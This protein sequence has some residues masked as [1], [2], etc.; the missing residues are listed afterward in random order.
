MKQLYSIL[1]ILTIGIPFSGYGRESIDPEITPALFQY[2]DE[3]TVTYNV[4]DT[5]LADF[6]NAW[7]WVWI[8]GENID[9]KYNVN[10]ANSDPTTSD[11]AKFTKTEDNGQTFFSITFVPADF[12]EQDIS[13]ETQLGM[14]LKGN[15]WNNGN[16]QTSDFVTDFWDGSFQVKLTSPTQQPLFVESGEEITISAETPVEADFELFINDISVNSQNAI[17]QFSYNHIVTETSGF[18]T[19]RIEAT[20]DGNT[21]ETGFQYIISGESI[22]EPRPSGII[23]GI[24]YDPTDDTKVT[25]CL[26][27]PGKNS[28]YALGDFSDWDVLPENIMKKDGGYFWLE[29]DGLTAGQEYTFQ[30]LVDE[31]LFIADPFAE[32]IL[33]PDDQYIPSS[34]YPNLKQLP[35]KAFKTDWWH[36]RFSVFQT[37]QEEFNWQN[38]DSQLP[39]KEDFVIYELLIRDFFAENDRNYLNLI[40]TLSYLKSLGVNAI[41]LMPIQEFAGNNSWGYNPTFMFAP[42]KA[43]GT[44][45]AL[46]QFIDAAHGEGMA[47]ILDIV[48]N[49]QDVPNPYVGM[50]FDYSTFQVTPDNPMFNVTATHPFSVFFD[51]NH[52]SPLTQY[53]MDTTL[54]YWVDEYKIDG[55]RFDLSKG[56]TQTVNTDVGLWSQR[57][58]SR[59]AILKRMADELW[60]EHPQTYVILEHFADNSEEKELSDY[61]MILWGN[62]HW[63][64][65]DLGIGTEKDISWTYYGNRDWEDP[66]LVSYMESHDE[67]RVMLE[68]MENGKSSGNYTVK[69]KE[70]ALNRIKALSAFFYTVPGP[71][72]LW[73]FGELAYDKSINQ[74][75]D[76]SV[77]DGCRTS[78]KPVLWEYYSEDDRYKLYQTIAELTKLKTTYDVFQTGQ[79]SMTSGA[80]LRKEI[81]LANSENISS[82][83]NE[84][85][86]S[87][88]LIG[89]FDVQSIN[90]NTNFPFTGTWYSFFDGGEEWNVENVNANISLKPGEFKLFVNY[91]IDF[92]DAEIVNPITSLNDKFDSGFVVYPNPSSGTF[93]IRLEEKNEGF[94][95][96]EIFDLTGKKIQSGN[97]E[98]VRNEIE[99]NTQSLLPGTYLLVL[100]NNRIHY[101]SQLIKK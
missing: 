89:N 14:L 43:Y 40:D 59:I 32:K 15:D 36:N 98:I 56:F 13:N 41:E 7:I 33:D 87:V 70:N 8:P 49:H 63:D 90:A 18:A 57:D 26:L 80:G 88:Y 5:H 64:Y 21:E 75:E 23:P 16:D 58:D 12:F 69:N 9:A 17:T 77:N 2:D 93:T 54:V 83:S 19:V 11:N 78:P 37:A 22:E 28:V 101:T 30:Y 71:K 85:E 46:K 6:E 45:E 100:S 99:L 76:G 4:T 1:F 82:P 51:F 47:V 53:Y 68:L 34:I 35:S 10:P 44:E 74:C 48:F 92:P 55:Y 73:Q 62:S 52:E 65:K 24:N 96:A 84:Q 95:K 79:F 91:P 61:G 60:A 3:I 86:M 67:E 50:W 29:I 38:S 66:N 31:E 27:A 72:M 20:F 25:L 39:D 97:K 42:D 81:T 94:V